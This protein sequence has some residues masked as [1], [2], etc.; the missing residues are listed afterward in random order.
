LRKTVLDNTTAAED[1]A[2]AES[3][4]TGD[5]VSADSDSSSTQTAP[6]HVELLLQTLGGLPL[7]DPS[8]FL[9]VLRT[10]KGSA[11]DGTPL[12]VA[13]A[14]ATVIRGSSGK[15]LQSARFLNGAIWFDG[16]DMISLL[17]A[18]APTPP[19]DRETF[20]T[21]LAD[22][23][24][25]RVV[26]SHQQLPVQQVS[27]HYSVFCVWVLCVCAICCVLCVQLSCYGSLSL[28]KSSANRSNI[29]LL[30]FVHII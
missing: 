6:I 23:R 1:A 30:F 19:S 14:S 13:S 15:A 8:A 26:S 22:C 18:L 17:S 29:I 21:S 9:S 25:R 11:R 10:L 2:A 27:K 5:D 4:S 7:S 28:I 20:Y 16:T 24:P 12:A 3:A